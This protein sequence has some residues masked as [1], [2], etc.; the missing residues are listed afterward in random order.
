MSDTPSNLW[1]QAWYPVA[2]LRDLDPQAPQRFV[3]LGQPLVIWFE[4]GE[5]IW[6]VFADVCPHRLVPL[7][8]GRLSSDGQL[9]CPYHGWQFDGAGHCTLIP[10]AAADLTPS[11]H[12]NS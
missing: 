1:Q 5:G 10:Q 4:R 7:S 6:R 12:V 9:E 8:E 3:L 2:Y 11:I